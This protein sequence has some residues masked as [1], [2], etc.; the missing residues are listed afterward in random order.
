MHIEP[1]FFEEQYVERIWGG[2]RFEELFGLPLP[3]GKRIG[4][5]WAVSDHPSAESVVRAGVY[6]GQ[7]LRQLIARDVKS[8]LGS[9][10]ALTPHGRFPLLLKMLDASDTLSVQ[11]HPDDETARQLGEPDVGKT[12]MWHVLD[13]APGSQLICGLNPS[14]TPED[15]ERAIADNTLH[16]WMLSFPVEEGASAFVP[17]GIVHAIGGGIVL[18][19]IQQN[20][21]LTYRLYDW[22]RVQAD[23][24][25]RELHIDKSLKAIHFGAKHAGRAE[26]LSCR[27]QNAERC[28]LAVCRYFA[29]EL[30]EM[31]GGSF[32]RQVDGRTFHILLGKRGVMYLNVGGENVAM[33]PG[34]A[35]LVPGCALQFTLEGKGAILDYYVPDVEADIIAPLQAA[36]H[37]AEA[38][39]RLGAT[40]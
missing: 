28:I 33:A 40:I 26:P 25:P 32:T 29:A 6:E 35:V 9:R 39:A 13:A 8:I 22:G 7:T 30:L 37:S 24:A 11:V 2:R 14:A 38:I 20:S 16:Q 31:P 1:L 17:A 12:E 27:E 15:I 3:E 23:G 5:V 19:E 10:P 18:A 4:E 21:D 34:Q 36:G